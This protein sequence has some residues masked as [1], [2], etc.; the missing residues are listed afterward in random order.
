MEF[1]KD[2]STIATINAQ[3]NLCG[4]THYVDQQTLRF[5]HSRILSARATDRGLL[6]AIT[7]SDA[8]DINNSR[9]EFRFVVFNLFG[10][11]IARPEL[12]QGFRTHQQAKKAMWAALNNIDAI[13]HTLVAVDRAKENF[14]KEMALLMQPWR[15]CAR[16]RYLGQE[17]A[18]APMARAFL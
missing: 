13:A 18:L 5:H 16:N 6:F 4:R 11:V 7:T 10:N 3:R 1:Y 2:Q 9:R 15:P 12:G 17:P 8:V 14:A